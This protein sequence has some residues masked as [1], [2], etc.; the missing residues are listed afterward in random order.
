MSAAAMLSC[1]VLAMLLGSVWCQQC[2]IDQHRAEDEKHTQCSYCTFNREGEAKPELLWATTNSAVLRARVCGCWCRNKTYWFYRNVTIEKGGV[3]RLNTNEIL[4]KSCFNKDYCEIYGSTGSNVM[5]YVAFYNYNTSS[6]PLGN[7]TYVRFCPAGSPHLPGKVSCRK[8]GDRHQLRWT[9]NL[10]T[11][12][13]HSYTQFVVST[14]HRTP[15]KWYWLGEVSP[16]AASGGEPFGGLVHRC[17]DNPEFLCANLSAQHLQVQMGVR[18]IDTDEYNAQSATDWITCE[19]R[20]LPSLVPTPAPAA[21]RTEQP[22]ATA[23]AATASGRPRRHHPCSGRD[24]TL[25]AALIALIV[26]ILLLPVA[27]YAGHRS[28]NRKQLDVSWQQLRE[29]RAELHVLHG[30]ATTVCAREEP[31]QYEYDYARGSLPPQPPQRSPPPPPLP[32]LP[33]PPLPA[34]PPPPGPPPRAP[35]CAEELNYLYAEPHK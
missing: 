34:L 11:L 23:T 20:L 14:D 3:S 18:R 6:T 1:A 15:Q 12:E 10:E 29:D 32:A 19:D 5:V 16:L 25:F 9:Y 26:C 2:T 17:P 13:C 8:H 27:F 35:A 22:L 4:L 7:G 31:P 24:Y 30:S 21:G 28:N 33:P